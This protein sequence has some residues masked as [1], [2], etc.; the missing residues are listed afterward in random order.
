MPLRALV[1]LWNPGESALSAGGFRRTYE[2][3]K[4]FTPELGVLHV[5]DAAPSYIEPVKN[6][7][8][9]VYEYHI[10]QAIKR[11]ERQLYV[12]ERLLEWNWS[13]WAILRRGLKLRRQYDVIYV[14]YSEL[15][16]VTLPAMVLRWLTKKPVVLCNL[17]TAGNPLTHVL[18]NI[19]HRWADEVMTISHD[20]QSALHRQGI[21]RKMPINYT[22][23]DLAFIK[24]QPSQAKSF[25]AIFVGR[26]VPSKGIDDYL[27]MLPLVV[28]EKPDFTLVSIGS[29]APDIESKITTA[30]KQLGLTKHWERRGVVS[31]EEKYALIKQAKTM[32]FL[33]T[34][35]GWGIVPQEALA[36][37]TLPLCYDLP[38][39]KES[40]AECE[41]ASFV[42]TG[43]WQ[44]AARQA[45][46]LLNHSPA[47]CKRLYT[48]GKRFVERFD[49]EAIAK[50]EYAIIA[51]RPLP[52]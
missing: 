44:E 40:I 9:H 2:I 14:P 50:R 27:H 19:T 34:L 25:D 8:I 5:I 16:V 45:L 23:I 32:W 39:Y 15:M 20:L 43:D 49:W 24:K 12:V 42:P 29:C 6:E 51:R 38:V 17:N 7:A 18:Q 48:I 41:A 46:V 11:L 33:S 35:E 31:E 13:M 4:R 22:G 37:G 36:C 26:H 52:K 3:I 47:E 10:P 21:K 1:L 30:L 28:K